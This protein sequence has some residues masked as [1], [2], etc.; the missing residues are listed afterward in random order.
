MSDKNIILIGA[1][2]VGKSTIGRKIAKKLN[3]DFFDS[4]KEIEKKTGVDI[5]TIFEY[6]G[7]DGFRSRE[8]KIISQLCGSDNFVLATGGGAILSDK[9][10]ALL[11]S[12]GIVFYLKASVDTL[13]NRTQA[14]SNR[15]LL[16]SSDRK[17]VITKL[18]N[19]REGLYQQTANHVINTDKHTINW[20][21]T[22]IL[23][24]LG[25]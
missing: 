23:K 16:E 8:E 19:E 18:L 24:K 20:A 1:M 25:L 7:E 21:V 22:Q 13:F 2:G 3:K 10:R 14:D 6:E 9:T 15:P 4:D 12:R 5:S 17:K 11:K